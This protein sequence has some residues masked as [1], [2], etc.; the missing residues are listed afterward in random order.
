MKRLNGIDAILLY[1]ETPNVH[2]HTLKVAIV[3]NADGHFTL[4]VFRE[5]TA[6][7]LHLLEPLSYKLIDIPRR[8]HHPMW[9]QNCPLDLDYHIRST[10]MRGM[11]DREDLDKTIAACAGGTRVALAGKERHQPA[12]DECAHLQ[13]SPGCGVNITVWSYIDD[14][15]ISVIADDLTLDAPGELTNAMVEA[16]SEIRCARTVLL[17]PAED[18]IDR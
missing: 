17:H 8:L 10:R 3:D 14:L 9:L 15:T 12:A 6:Q 4:E 11:G 18:R 16:F 2:T 1:S 5:A 7:Q 13:R